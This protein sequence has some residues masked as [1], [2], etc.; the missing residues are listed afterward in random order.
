MK[1]IEYQDSGE[2]E[3]PAEAFG[4]NKWFRLGQAWVTGPTERDTVWVNIQSGRPRGE[5]PIRL[6]GQRRDLVRF[7]DQIVRELE[8]MER[9]R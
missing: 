9:A 7:L 2:G 1:T 5:A 4:R 8:R 6:R 3:F